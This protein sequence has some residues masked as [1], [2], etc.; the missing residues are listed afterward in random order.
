[1]IDP[2]NPDIS[3][4]RHGDYRLSGEFAAARLCANVGLVKIDGG[5]FEHVQ[6]G[7]FQ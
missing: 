1:M 6:P 7:Q 2:E 5:D 4:T 3:R